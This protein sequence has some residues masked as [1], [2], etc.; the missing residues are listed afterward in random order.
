MGAV[1]GVHLKYVF[2]SAASAVTAYRYPDPGLTTFEHSNF[3]AAVICCFWYAAFV[4]GLIASLFILRRG[5]WILGKSPQTGVV[6]LWSYIIF[7]AFH[8]P[9]WLYTYV[10][11]QI[12]KREGVP[13]ASEV[14]DGWWIG[15]C[16]ASELGKPRWAATIDLTTEFTESCFDTSD[17]YLLL[18]CWDGVPPKPHDIERAA[19][20]AAEASLR[21][22]DIMVHCAHGRGRSTCVM[23]ACLVRAGV[24]ATWQD[25]FEACA[26]RRKGVK[27]NGKMR[28]ALDEWAK[29]SG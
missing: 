13:V 9:T 18:R 14:A 12:S 24:Y 19:R 15:G 5:E 27:L 29:L 10:H 11:T 7:A 17:R 4:H 1:H 23:V 22:G 21:G 8:L 28:R 26:K 2:M 16:Y 3:D 20:F 25:A 6:P